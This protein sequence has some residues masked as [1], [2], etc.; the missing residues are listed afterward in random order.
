MYLLLSNIYKKE[1]SLQSTKEQF[2]Q[3]VSS[4]AL[5]LFLVCLLL[6]LS[7]SDPLPATAE[8]IP[9]G[10]IPPTIL[11]ADQLQLN[12]PA[13]AQAG[14]FITVLLNITLPETVHPTGEAAV[15]I[16]LEPE[17]MPVTA[18]VTTND[19]T[20]DAAMDL[21]TRY[22]FADQGLSCTDLQPQPEGLKNFRNAEPHHFESESQLWIYYFLNHFEAVQPQTLLTATA[23]VLLLADENNTQLPDTIQVTASLLADTAAGECTLQGITS[24][25]IKTHREV[26]LPLAQTAQ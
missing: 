17:V 11:H 12:V 15:T 5:P 16:Q 19:P 9:P 1:K 22:S 25:V 24:A 23:K 8:T 13:Y 4:L 26:Y 18:T 7:E 6:Y 3:L 10:T 21:Q 20:I 2:L 14:S